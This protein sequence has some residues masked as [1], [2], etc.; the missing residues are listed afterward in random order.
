MF[1]VGL[2]ISEMIVERLLEMIPCIGNSVTVDTW[3]LGWV[4]RLG[5]AESLGLPEMP[6][7][8]VLQKVGEGCFGVVPP[9]C[10]WCHRHLASTLLRYLHTSCFGKKPFQTGLTLALELQGDRIQSH[11]GREGGAA[12]SRGWEEDA[13]PGADCYLAMS[14]FGRIIR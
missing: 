13:G 1:S 10:C 8:R 7:R 14:S 9:H 6:G 12:N 3:V 4:A 11:A 5:E 2:Y